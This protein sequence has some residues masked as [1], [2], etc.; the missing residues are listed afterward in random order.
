MPS[1][2]RDLLSSDGFRSLPPPPPAAARQPGSQHRPGAKRDP[3]TAPPRNRT[4]L[5]FLSCRSD[6]AV[7]IPSQEPIPNSNAGVYKPGRELERAIFALSRSRSLA[8]CEAAVEVIARAWIAAAAGGGAAATTAISSAAVA[9][10]LLEVL[11]ASRD[12]AIAEI[13]MSLLADLVSHSEN[14]RKA[15]LAA[16]PNLETFF[17]LLRTRKLFL[18]AAVLLYLLRPRS[19]NLA[20]LEWIP[21]VLRVLQH[22]DSRQRLF[23]VQ[24]RPRSAAFYLLEQLLCKCDAEQSRKN[25][26]QVMAMRGLEML[27]WRFEDGDERQACSAGGLI[28]ACVRADEICA[29]FVVDRLK[30][31]SLVEILAGNRVRSRDCALSLL[32]ELISRSRRTKVRGFLDELKNSGSINAMHVLLVY[33][34]KAPAE[35]RPLAAAILLQIDLLLGDPLQHSVYREEAIDALMEAMDCGSG[36]KVQESCS[37]AIL[38]LCSRFSG[39]GEASM[40][41]WLLIKSGFNPIGVV[42]Y[43]LDDDE[44]AEMEDW[45]KRFSS[46]FLRRR[47]ERFSSSLSKCLASGIPSLARS[48]LVMVTW[49]SM[50]ISASLK[51]PHL[52]VAWSPLVPALLDRLSRDRAMEERVLA[53][54]SLRNIIQNH[55][56]L[57]SRLLPLDRRSTALLRDLAEV[58][59][60]AKEVLLAVDPTNPQ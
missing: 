15:V 20:A 41:A 39:S 22:G 45:R 56:L 54:F 21:L 10:G 44:E 53:A 16:D 6:S 11:L 7:A 8:E 5:R 42:F 29:E 35:Q 31:A 37:K 30:K 33:L 43:P 12:D 9:E 49:T 50:S 26:R 40:E 23:S 60:A 4:P 2:L 13:A 19:K 34:Q 18:K 52:A 48:C 59:W 47:G 38:F 1:S 14:N 17:K 58:T 24:C 28:V 3:V 27:I 51:S 36:R 55:D 46:I 57:L 32:V 25:A